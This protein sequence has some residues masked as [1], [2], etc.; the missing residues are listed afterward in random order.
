MVITPLAN[1]RAQARTEPIK[2][3]RR[4][5]NQTLGTASTKLG[6][7]EKTGIAGM[8]SVSTDPFPLYITMSYGA[9]ST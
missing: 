7:I 3:A 9:E 5:G 4:M 1:G 6:R 8:A 2:K